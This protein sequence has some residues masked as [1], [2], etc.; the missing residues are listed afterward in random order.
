MVRGIGIFS[1]VVAVLAAIAAHAAPPPLVPRGHASVVAGQDEIFVSDPA[2]PRV[3]K[4]KQPGI[5]TRAYVERMAKPKINPVVLDE[6]ARVRGPQTPVV[7][8]SPEAPP[9]ANAAISARDRVIII[10]GDRLVAAVQGGLSFDHGGNGAFDVINQVLGNYGDEF[11]FVTVFTTFEDAGTAAYYLPFKNDVDGLGECDFQN[12]RTFGCLFDQFD[13]QL[14]QLHGFVFM[15]SLRYWQDWDENYDG[16]VHPF[17]SFDSAVFSTLGQEIAHRWGSGLRFVDQRSNSVSNLLLGRDNSHWAGSVDTDASVMDGWDWNVTGSTFDLVGD[18]DRYS[19]LDLYTIGALPVAA[20]KP[21]FVIDDAAFTVGGQDRIGIDG[22]AIPADIV[23]QLPSDALMEQI[24]MKVGATGINVPVTIQD[25]VDAEGNRCP[26]PD[27]TQK[28]FRQAIVLV[29]QPGQTIAQ[30]EAAG[31]V[32]DLDTVLLTWEQ[33]W[34]ERTNKRMK[35][36]TDLAGAC[37]HGEQSLGGDV[38]FDGDSVQPGQTASVTL[39]VSATGSAVENA[40]IALRAEGA[41][42]EFMT[43]PTSVDVGTVAAGQTKSV[44]F[45]VEIASDYPCGNGVIIV[46]TSSSDTAA[47]VTEELRLFPGLKTVFEETF[48]AA[49]EKFVVNVDG[50]D[51]TTAADAGALVH[52]NPVELTCDMSRRTPERDASVNDNGAFL[53]G[54]GT[55]HI[56]NQA[57]NDPG[58]GS[59][60]DG[61]TSL[62]GPSL[63]LKDLRDPELRFAYWFDGASGD[64]LRVQ[65][66][67]D[68]E[69]TFVTGKE[70]TESFHGWVVGRVSVRDVFD[71]KLPDAVTARFLFEGNGTLEGGIDDIRLLDYD[72]DC[73]EVARA[74]G[75]CGC[76]Q[77]GNATPAMPVAVMLGLAG[78]RGL[79]RRRRAS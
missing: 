74:G 39:T 68:G 34:L 13:G 36:C 53:T 64:R 58:K 9:F 38:A 77:N 6:L 48:G 44:S 18:M 24:G 29:T 47:D 62:W 16:V 32:R 33:W 67:G 76:D 23:L 11:D 40:V 43:L 45:D 14:N 12:G 63:D 30:A 37:N 1:I 55:D 21:F 60:L 79:R 35:L 57:D 66:S 54:P 72:G 71:G 3:L 70:I 22:R 50:K 8:Q 27:A 51:A 52:T 28:T 73:L 4:S 61:D 15:N 59:E 31:F 7:L 26:D 69:K 20:A 10:E 75:I 56:P 65:L 42:A 46:A 2:S 78:L 25:V 17:D 41:G 49:T 19:T 5:L